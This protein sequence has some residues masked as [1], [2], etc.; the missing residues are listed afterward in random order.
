[1]KQFLKTLKGAVI[2]TVLMAVL[3]SVVYPAVTIILAQTFFKEKANGSLIYAD[4]TA[5]GSELVGQKWEDPRFFKGR[6]SSVNYN[7]YTDEEKENGS[8]TGVASGTYNYGPTNEK[9][10]DRVEEA[11]AAF[12][13]EYKKATGKELT[14]EIPADLFTAS[15][16][17][18][19]P[20]IS[21]AAARIQVPIVAA[22]SG[23][24]EG[25][26]N[27][28]VEAHT[29]HKLL[30]IFGEERVNVLELNLD[31]AKKLGITA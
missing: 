25:E 24:D 26:V 8:Y 16:S 4:G 29:E 2:L 20:D 13:E 17:G 27:K 15:G 14:E 9:L 3:S 28:L 19:D 21:P 6:P 22:A 7:V 23:L 18:L 30:G 1:M 5:I 12:K 11:V 10:T 31:L